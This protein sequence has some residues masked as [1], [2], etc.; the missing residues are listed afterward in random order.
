MEPLRNLNTLDA[1]PRH[2]TVQHP[3]PTALLQLLF[4]VGPASN[5]I[6]TSQN[7]G[8]L[9][10]LHSG[11]SRETR[12]GCDWD[13]TTRSGISLAHAPNRTPS[14][15]HWDP[16][17]PSH[18]NLFSWMSELGLLVSFVGASP[19]GLFAD[20]GLSVELAMLEAVS[21]QF[22]P[23][24]ACTRAP[25]L[26]V[27]L[28]MDCPLHLPAE[29]LLSVLETVYGLHC[30]IAKYLGPDDIGPIG[31]RFADVWALRHACRRVRAVSYYDMLWLREWSWSCGCRGPYTYGSGCDI[32]W[33][34]RGW[35]CPVTL[36]LL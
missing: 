8:I 35:V 30:T 32:A 34:L 27:L 20:V 1:H 28:F 12:V 31:M 19:V 14:D 17:G 23:L 13:S 26:R 3:E 9:F 36:S 4:Q 10:G 25:C 18:S 7:L 11:I 29:T 2:P 21:P 15:S 24:P 5:H 22:S 6:G 33:R 16:T